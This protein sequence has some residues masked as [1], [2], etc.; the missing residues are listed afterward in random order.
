MRG[1]ILPRAANRLV[2]PEVGDRISWRCG[3]STVGQRIEA[4]LPE[5]V[6]RDL[7]VV[8]GWWRWL[9]V[10]A[11]VVRIL[12][13]QYHRSRTRVEIDVTWACNLRCFNCNRSCE[14]APTR[15]RVTLRQIRRFVEDSVS[16]GVQWERVRVLGGEPTLHP[17]LLEIVDL[18][19]HWRDNHAPKARIELVTN[20]HGV[21]VREALAIIPAD[22]VIENTSKEDREQ[23]FQPFNVAPQD[24]PAYRSADFRSGC[25]VIENCGVGLTP[26]GWYPC[27]VAGGIDRILERDLGREALPDPSDDMFVELNTFCRVCG[28][29]ERRYRPPVTQPVKS[30]TWSVAYAQHRVRRAGR[31]G[32]AD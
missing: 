14:Q 28:I 16:R 32:R 27:A 6:L 13:P 20:G 26:R 8:L 9:R 4:L 3:V 10:Q 17:D 29:F 31:A 12:G 15:D 30:S 18:L 23:P 11:P 19:R 25:D 1:R 24:L 7:R 2:L 21:S 22:I 5:G